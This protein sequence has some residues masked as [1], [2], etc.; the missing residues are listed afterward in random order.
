MATE[1]AINKGA[2]IIN[3]LCWWWLHSPGSLQDRAA[4]VN[5]SGVVEEGGLYV[6]NDWAAVRP[7]LWINLES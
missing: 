5:D 6:N 1:Y 7:A 4:F 3:A 2:D